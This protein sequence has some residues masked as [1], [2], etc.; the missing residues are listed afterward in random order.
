MYTHNTSTVDFSF[1]YEELI[2]DIGNTS[3]IIGDSPASSATV[4]MASAA[5]PGA[6][7]P[8][9]DNLPQQHVDTTINGNIE[10][11]ERHLDTAWGLVLRIFRQSV[12]TNVRHHASLNDRQHMRDYK[13]TMHVPKDFSESDAISIDA[14]THDFLVTYALWRWCLLTYPAYA[15]NWQPVIDHLQAELKNLATSGTRIY[16][17]PYYPAI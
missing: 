2:H 16:H 10:K 15:S 3:F 1:L 6:A 7:A 12:K 4:P 13:M 8:T 9:P 14:L 11:I 17:R 5:A